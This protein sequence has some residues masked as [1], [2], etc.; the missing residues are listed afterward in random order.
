MLRQDPALGRVDV[1]ASGAATTIVVTALAGSF[2]DDHW[3][4]YYLLRSD[5]AAE[6]RQRRCSDFTSSSG[7][8]TQPGPDYSDTTFT[9]ESVEILKHAPHLYDLAINSALHDMR[10]LDREIIPTTGSDR[11]SLVDIAWITREDQIHRVLARSSPI[12]SRNRHF[13][14]WNSISSAGALVPDSFTLSGASATMAREATVKRSRKYSVAVTR[15]GTNA[16]LAQE[17]GLLWNSVSGDSLRSETVTLVGVGRS[18]AAS[19]LRFRINDGVTTSYT[20]Y[21]TGG[22]TFEELTTEVTVGAAATQLEIA[23]VLETDETAYVDELYLI[24]GSIG[25]AARADVY[26]ERNIPYDIEEEAEAMALN[27]GYAKGIG[28]Q[29]I[30]E[31]H[32]PYLPFATVLSGDGYSCDAPLAE[33]AILARAELYTTL[34]A[35]ATDPKQM[36]RFTGLAQMAYL[37][38]R[39]ARRPRMIVTPPRF[40]SQGLA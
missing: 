22:A 11:Y 7:T 17:V 4:G 35:E 34:A 36:A 1:I 15:A 30:I 9:S 14:K 18:G 8:L 21:H 31:A 38:S 25:D 20:S 32:R 37:E 16:V 26:S 10:F 29:L 6:A 23:A 27:I 12:L 33:V 28:S 40:Y 13:D 2:P 3:N 39:G 19:S 5:S 24:W